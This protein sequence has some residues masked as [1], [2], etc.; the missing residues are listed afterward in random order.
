[1][2]NITKCINNYQNRPYF[3][4]R[5]YE[6]ACRW[7]NMTVEEGYIYIGIRI[8]MGLHQENQIVDYWRPATSFRAGHLPIRN[9]IGLKRFQAIHS[10]FRLYADDPNIHIEGIFDKVS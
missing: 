10:A 8:Y 1:M 9:T 5:P 6:R 3:V 4:R 7:Y 2:E